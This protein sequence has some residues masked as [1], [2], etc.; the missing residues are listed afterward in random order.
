MDNKHLMAIGGMV[1]AAL[2]LCGIFAL[3]LYLDA[4]RIGVLALVSA[5]LAY[6]GYVCGY[7]Q[8]VA[9]TRAAQRSDERWAMAFTYLSVLFAALGGIALLTRL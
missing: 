8:L 1:N 4:P 9:T 5:A 7:S 6:S 2:Y 3:A